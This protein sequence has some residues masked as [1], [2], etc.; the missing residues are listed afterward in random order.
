MLDLIVTRSDKVVAQGNR[1]PGHN[2]Q[3]R[4]PPGVGRTGPRSRNSNISSRVVARSDKVVA[5]SDKL[6]NSSMSSRVVVRSDKVVARSDKLLVAASISSPVVAR[7]DKHVVRV[8]Q[9]VSWALHISDP[10][11]P[12]RFAPEVHR[13]TLLAAFHCNTPVSSPFFTNGSN[14]RNTC[15][16]NCRWQRSAGAWW[17]WGGVWV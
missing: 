16:K 13:C 17:G 3:K 15:N 14:S 10:G 5:R 4:N 8:S 2:G 9:G 7:S 1:P 11:G 12:T 6:E